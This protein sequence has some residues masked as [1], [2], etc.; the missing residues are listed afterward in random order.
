MVIN[1]AADFK[2]FQEKRM[3]TL[4]VVKEPQQKIWSNTLPNDENTISDIPSSETVSRSMY[5]ICIFEHENDTDEE[6]FVLIKPK[7]PNFESLKEAIYERIP[8]LKDQPL[9]IFTQGKCNFF[10]HFSIRNVNLQWLI[11]CDWFF[12]N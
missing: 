2:I 10:F 11:K 8:M 6:M 4:F 3:N 9:N 12:L 7:L 1:A 5:K